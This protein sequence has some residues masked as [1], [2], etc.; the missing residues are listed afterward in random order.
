MSPGRYDTPAPRRT[1]EQTD[2]QNWHGRQ[3]RAAQ[4]AE[5][6][7]REGLDSVE[8]GTPPAGTDIAVFMVAR[9]VDSTAVGCG[10]LRQLDEYTAEIKRMYVLPEYRGRGIAGEIVAAL[11]DFAR[12]MGWRRLVLETGDRL[13]EAAGLYRKLGYR[14]I[15]LFGDYL[16]SE[17]SLC[18]AKDLPVTPGTDSS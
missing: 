8:A 9:E 17:S 12:T 10:A 13:P 15:P 6:R 16:G 2:W 7:E 18:F 5:I 14:S 3:L 11:E 4:Q 1:V